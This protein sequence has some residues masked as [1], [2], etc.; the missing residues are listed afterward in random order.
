[1]IGVRKSRHSR[2]SG[3][4]CGGDKG[5]KESQPHAAYPGCHRTRM[6]ILERAIVSSRH[7]GSQN[8]RLQQPGEFHMLGTA[9]GPEILGPS[10]SLSQFP[11]CSPPKY[12]S[13]VNRPRGDAGRN[14]VRYKA[15]QDFFRPHP[16]LQRVNLR[17]MHVPGLVPFLTP[18]RC[19][20]A[21]P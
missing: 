11:S 6:Q 17:P 16:A 18:P 8:I 15:V 14:C 4:T 20:A 12:A 5:F 19:D 21:I 3:H 13:G 2:A 1:M 10:S 7:H 9:D